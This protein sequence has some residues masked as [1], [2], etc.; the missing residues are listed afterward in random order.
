MVQAA[1]ENRGKNMNEFRLMIVEDNKEDLE[2]CK[3]TIDRYMDEKNCSINL[4]ECESFEEFESKMDK[5]I[6]GAIIDLNL[7]GLK[8][9]GNEVIKQIEDSHYRIPVAVL[10]GK[11]GDLDTEL[12]YI[13]V[14]KKGEEGSGYSDLMDRFMEIHD[15][16]ITK[17]MGGTGVIEETLTEVF[18]K[19]FIEKKLKNKWVEY[20]KKDSVKTEKALLRHTLN[21][22]LQLL[23]DDGDQSFPEEMYLFPPLTEDIRTGSLVKDK[24]DNFYVVMN[25]ACDLVIRNRGGYKTDRILISEIED[26]DSVVK[27]ALGDASKKKWEKL[28]KP[29]F[30]NNYT[31][32]YHWLPKTDFFQGGFINFRK[33]TTMSNEEFHEKFKT[34]D[35]QI[36]P[37]FVKDVVARFSSYYA[38]QGQ[39]DINCNSSISCILDSK[40][41]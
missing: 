39:P 11:P 1:T 24:N 21:H 36:S 38:R 4:V 9:E 6:D 20:G 5:S 10:T 13:G 18:K 3:S 8:N 31:E 32:Y 12:T 19:S 25:P 7:S 23:D 37:S 29:V 34:P 35:I 26:E 27:S 15:T 14:F 17:I 30:S 28:L 33:L 2:N 22:L 41:V 40:E 16:G